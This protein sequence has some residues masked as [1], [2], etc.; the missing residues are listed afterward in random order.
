[1]NSS[2]IEH[3]DGSRRLSTFLSGTGAWFGTV[4]PDPFYLFANNGA[5]AL[6][7]GTNGNVS[8]GTPFPGASPLQINAPFLPPLAAGLQVNHAINGVDIQINRG[9]G[10]GGTG[11]L[12]DN[13]GPGDSTT[14]LLLL[15]N[16]VAVSPQTV[17]DVQADGKVGIQS[18]TPG[19]A[20]Q[21][22]D[23]AVVGSEG[24]IRLSSRT[25]TGGSATRTWD[26]GVPQTSDNASGIGYSFVINDAPLGSSTPQLLV[27]WGTGNVGVGTTNPAAKLHVAG[28]LLATGNFI[29]SGS[30]LTNIPGTLTW[31]I[32]LGSSQQAQPN[33]GY[34]ATNSGQIT[35]TLPSSANINPGDIVRISGLGSGGWKL[36]QNSDQSVFAGNLA[37]NVGAV[38][39]AQASD[40]VNWTSIAS[41]LDGTKLVAASLNAVYTSS[42]SGL[43]WS[44]RAHNIGEFVASSA[45][46]IKLVIASANGVISTSTDSGVTWTSQNS[47]SRFFTSVASSAD[48]TKLVAT[49]GGLSQG[50]IY[51]SGDSGVT[52]TN[53]A[54]AQYWK[55]VAA[56]ADG[57]KLV[58]ATTS[59][60][61]TSS[62][63]GVTWTPNGT[64]GS[65][66]S[67]ASSSD[68]TKLVA[69]SGG[70][71]GGLIYTSGDSGLT[72]TPH[73]SARL[74]SSVASSADGSKLV[75]AV[76][77][78][79]IYT[80]INSGMTWV[81]RDNN[82]AW[83]SVASSADGTKLAA[84]VNLAPIFTSTPIT[85]SNTSVG[86]YLLG[87][88]HTA[89][90]L[91]YAGNGQFVAL[92]Q[93]GNMLGF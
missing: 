66:T 17:L 9:P 19:K 30:G 74:W 57:T 16:N 52:W 41:S 43:T 69:A 8:I 7:I 90:E 5:P 26:I 59:T 60:I 76:Q 3:T 35:V 73:D 1:V 39:T 89:V 58:A 11:L 67:V 13:S 28:D 63:S 71:A 47:G 12:V 4:S 2:G 33:T 27:Q 25:D 51:I 91:Q 93:V 31:Q 92:S 68:G 34:F 10:Q 77:G 29:G 40:S 44:N 84:V 14:S 78:G 20:L 80:S 87:G 38:W 83:M 24:M 36:A 15:R 21:V 46:G 23:P 62:D 85:V 82:R 22:G 65:W 79:H 53:R 54:S 45:D 48:G 6:T 86:G 75:A 42:D 70:N 32:V 18:S 88:P 50:L 55:S 61:Y 64:S 81:E 72:W 56:S 37:G 49:D